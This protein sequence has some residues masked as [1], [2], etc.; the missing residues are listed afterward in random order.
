ML[1]VCMSLMALIKSVAYKY[2]EGKAI[3]PVAPWSKKAKKT[4]SAEVE[5]R[6]FPDPALVFYPLRTFK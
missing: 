4:L 6:V 5:V 2:S 1:L 3:N